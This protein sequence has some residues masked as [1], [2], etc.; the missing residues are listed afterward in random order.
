MVEARERPRTVFTDLEDDPP[1]AP[2][3]EATPTPPQAPP[4]DAGFQW[5]AEVA[6]E[7]GRLVDKLFGYIKDTALLTGAKA[8]IDALRGQGAA[9]APASPNGASP[10]ASQETVTMTP[11]I[12]MEK[13]METAQEAVELIAKV[14]GSHSISELPDLFKQNRQAIKKALQDA[15][16]GA[17]V[18]QEAERSATAS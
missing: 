12:D 4:D 17:F 8:W 11:R 6:L 10:Q 13:L 1:P 5:D 15:I 16:G 7:T 14:Y 9:P 3:A 2:E 18:Y